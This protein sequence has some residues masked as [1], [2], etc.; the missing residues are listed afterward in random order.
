MIQ[1]I[2]D[3]ANLSSLFPCESG[4]FLKYFWEKEDSVLYMPGLSHIIDI[5]IRKDLR[6][7]IWAILWGGTLFNCSYR[8]MGVILSSDEI[9][10]W[11]GVPSPSFPGFWKIFSVI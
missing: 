9:R 7:K 4:V 6:L 8:K 3:R 5:I 11:T 10:Q 2:V 1:H